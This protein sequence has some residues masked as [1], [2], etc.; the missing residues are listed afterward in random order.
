MA[1]LIY[2]PEARFKI[3]EGAAFYEGCRESLGRAFLEAIEEAIREMALDPRR[4]HTIGG[5][6]RRCLVR[7]FPYG[8]IYC[9]EPDAIRIVAVMHL[10]RKPGYWRKRVQN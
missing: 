4:W 7:R 8:I 10:K 9:I 2:H 5:R 6:F 1:D 3:R